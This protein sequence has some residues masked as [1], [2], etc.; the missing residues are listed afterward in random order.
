[1]DDARAVPTPF[2][3]IDFGGPAYKAL[4]RRHASLSPSDAIVGFSNASPQLL[5]LAPVEA[6][7]QPTV[8]V[9]KADRKLDLPCPPQQGGHKKTHTGASPGTLTSAMSRAGAPTCPSSSS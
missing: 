9:G 1:M 3:Q 4:R 8:S 5:R 2:Y 6:G 7:G